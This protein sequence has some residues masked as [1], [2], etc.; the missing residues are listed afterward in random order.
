MGREVPARPRHRLIAPRSDIAA[1]LSRRREVKLKILVGGNRRVVA[2]WGDRL[3]LGYLLNPG[4]G[5]SVRQ[6]AESGLPWGL[7]N[8]AFGK[9]DPL[10]FFAAIGRLK[11]EPALAANLLF[12]VPPDTPF[13]AR[14]TLYQFWEWLGVLANPDETSDLPLALV[15][16]DGMEDC[17]W[18]Y[19]LGYS[20]CFFIGGTT[21]WKLSP[22]AAAL[23]AE[24]KRR[25]L[26]VH[27]GRVNSV[28]RLAYAMSIGCDSIDGTGLTKY[29]DEKMPRVK[30]FL[31]RQGATERR[32]KEIV[33]E[34]TAGPPRPALDVLEGCVGLAYDRLGPEAYGRFCDWLCALGVGG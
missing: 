11:R 20:D 28:K 6:A 13:H 32:Y 25:G 27:M 17:D 2:A 3:P 22:E 26:W 34:A 8:G 10:R 30:R 21:A 9:T 31:A 19:F 16:Q 23:A 12:V 5:V 18:D 1:C 7:D 29:A 33:A 14:P 4:G 24:A 15:G